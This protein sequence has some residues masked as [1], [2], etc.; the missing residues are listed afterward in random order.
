MYDKNS[1]KADPKIF[2]LGIP[3]LGI[4]YGHQWMAH[5]LGGKVKEGETKEYGY[6]EIHA[7][8]QADGL[9][10]DLKK[11]FSVWMSHGDEIGQ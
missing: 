4:C 8:D 2:D 6:S 9:L 1:P 3:V 11:D 7:T 5:T 10:R